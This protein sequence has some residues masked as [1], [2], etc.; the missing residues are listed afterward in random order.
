VTTYRI[1]LG[2][3]EDAPVVEHED[4]AG[5]LR[6]GD[7]IPV[8]GATWLIY[9]LAPVDREQGADFIAVLSAPPVILTLNGEHV[10]LYRGELAQL[11][12]EVARLV[13]ARGEP[14]AEALAMI[15][16]VLEEND[17][18][19]RLSHDALGVLSEALYAMEVS[20]GLSD[21]LRAVWNALRDH[22]GRQERR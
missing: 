8:D 11:R 22:L 15:V 1:A 6:I 14:A 21:R 12:R 5:S 17:P 19:P 3:A 4:P 7:E 20:D 10:E 9:S 18:P 16:S 13:D 2:T